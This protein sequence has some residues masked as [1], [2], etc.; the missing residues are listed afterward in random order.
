MMWWPVLSPLPELP[1]LSYPVQML[2]LFLMT[3]PMSI[4]A[5]YIAYARHLLYPG[6]RAR[7][8]DPR[9]SRRWTTS[10]IGG[11]IMWIP[12]GLFFFAIISVMFFR[13]QQHGA[14]DSRASAQV[15]WRPASRSDSGPCVSR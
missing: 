2:Y 4:V 13:W 12:G 10:C 14:E 3:L 6:V 1:R 7:A 8:E 9:A 5:V 11:L 15:D